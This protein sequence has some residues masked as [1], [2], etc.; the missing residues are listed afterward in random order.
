MNSDAWQN[1]YMTLAARIAEGAVDVERPLRGL[2]HTTARNFFLSERRRDRRLIAIADEQV[3]R[4]GAG[5]VRSTEELAEAARRGEVLRGHLVRLA[6][7]GKL[8][9]SDLI[10][11]TR[12]YV[13]GWSAAEVAEAMGLGV[14]N[15]RQ[16]CARR[17]RLLRTELA[18]LG[19]DEGADDLY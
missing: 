14:D 13:D 2:A 18:G 5:A 8:T 9:P 16:I 7:A 19:L 11:L 3:E 15:V 4:Y 12:R 6:A 17:R 1:T 10:I